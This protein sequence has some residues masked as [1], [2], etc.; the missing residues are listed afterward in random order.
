MRVPGLAIVMLLAFA[1]PAMAD[2]LFDACAALGASTYESGY[3]GVGPADTPDY[4]AYD[5]A[6][7][8]APAHDADPSNVALAAWLGRALLEQGKTEEAMPLLTRAAEGGNAVAQAVL[9]D[10]LMLGRGIP[11]DRA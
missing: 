11:R 4:S 8:C 2:D 10:A 7:A 3:V 9:G 1:A 5:A 6:D